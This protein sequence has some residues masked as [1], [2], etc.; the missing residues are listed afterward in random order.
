[1]C[2]G[3]NPTK[4]FI[5]LLRLPITFLVC[6][7]GVLLG[8]AAAGLIHLDRLILVLIATFFMEAVTAHAID[9]MYDHP[10]GVS[11]SK[12]TLQIIAMVGVVPFTFILAYFIEMLG[13]P[14]LIFGLIGFWT[15]LLYCSGIFH[16]EILMPINI[17]TLLLG[18]FYVQAETLTLRA[19]SLAAFSFLFIYGLLKIHRLRKKEDPIKEGRKALFLLLFS[20]IP[21]IIALGPG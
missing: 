6:F 20:Q 12:R 15:T 19:L 5:L 13:W 14:I 3:H 1:M 2:I 9:E 16:H 18:S 8:T 11:F 4:E 17:S 10:V 21:L 7:P